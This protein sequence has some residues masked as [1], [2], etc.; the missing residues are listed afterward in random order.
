MF[1]HIPDEVHPRPGGRLA[2]FTFKYFRDVSFDLFDVVF[3]TKPAK[4]LQCIFRRCCQSTKRYLRYLLVNAGTQSILV[5]EYLFTKGSDH[6]IFFS[7]SSPIVGDT[8]KPRLHETFIVETL[9]RY[10]HSTEIEFLF[11]F[12][13]ETLQDQDTIC[14]VA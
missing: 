11:K 9:Q 7:S 4:E 13:F 6:I 12:L 8:A 10:M 2:T 1:D 3:A 14:L 5:I